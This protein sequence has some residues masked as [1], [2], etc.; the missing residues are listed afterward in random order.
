[1]IKCIV[2]DDEKIILDELCTLIG[3]TEAVVEGAFSDPYEA[4]ESISTIRPDAVFCDIEMP[5]MNGIELARKIATYNPQIQ[6]V[7]VTAYEQYA[8]KAFEVCAVHYILKPL[9]FEKIDGAVKRVLRVRRMSEE[10]GEV[11]KPVVVK[12]KTGAVD[13]ISVKERDNVIILKV[14][15]ILYLKSEDGKTVIITKGGSYQ[16][17]TGLRFWESKLRKFDFIRCHRSFIVNANYI[18]KMIHILGEYR[19][20]ILDYCDANI[21]ISRQKVNTVKEWMGIM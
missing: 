2:V 16:S 9:T 21:P 18:T 5:G 7:F 17:R 1:M 11:D 4:L 6:V 13:R 12:S 19:E 8:L 20:L 10:K 3:Q 14:P 15:D